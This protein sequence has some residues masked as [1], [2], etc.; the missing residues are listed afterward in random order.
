MTHSSDYIITTLSSSITQY[1]TSNSQPAP[2]RFGV[3]V[4]PL[5]LRSTC[6]PYVPTTNPNSSFVFSQV[7]CSSDV[8]A[9]SI[10]A[11]ENL[12][13]WWKMNEG[14]TTSATDYGLSASEGTAL[15]M[16]GV[17]SE[18]GGPSANGTPDFVTFDGL[19]DKAYTLL[20]DEAQVNTA[21]GNLVDAGYNWTFSLWLK[22]EAETVLTYRTW[23]QGGN[24]WYAGFGVTG[25]A[26]DTMAFFVENYANYKASEAAAIPTF[27]WRNIVVTFDRQSADTNY[28]KVY[29]AGSEVASY[30]PHA[31]SINTEIGTLAGT[32]LSFGGLVAA[33]TT[34]VSYAKACSMSDIRMYNRVLTGVEISAIAAGDWA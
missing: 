15:T 7:S 34:T 26:S 21:V 30:G 1:N 9:S 33:N 18:T 3:P 16:V 27:G 4:A 28:M 12:M 24:G 2:F 23:W 29:F 5:N 6:L 13:H 19:T 8:A 17:T 31:D 32:K 11:N 10:T 22:D 20:I 25:V 14:S